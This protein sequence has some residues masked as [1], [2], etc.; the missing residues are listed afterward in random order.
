MTA[1]ELVED[2]H[3]EVTLWIDGGQAMQ[4]WEAPLMEASADLLCTF[5][6][7]FLEAG[8][9]LGISALRIAN[10][11]STR[12][13]VVVEK[14]RKV[15][16]LFAERHPDPPPALEI[17]HADFFE[18]IR[19]VE[20]GSL[21]GVFFDPYLGSSRLWEDPALWR[22]TMP[23]VVRALKEGGAFVPCFTVEPVL[24]WEFVGYFD[25]VIVERRRFTAYEGTEY[26]ARREGDAFIQCFIR[27]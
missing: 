9:G 14:H 17:V 8:L 5:G 21:D 18:H 25:R 2:D 10:A 22:A 1:I 3:G 4:R 19:T 13:H 15:I 23:A 6:S 11:E 24:R 7:R 12:R 20:P 26:T 27:L 16:D